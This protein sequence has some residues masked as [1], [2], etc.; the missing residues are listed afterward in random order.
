VGLDASEPEITEVPTP[1]YRLA[2]YTGALCPEGSIET[3]PLD[4]FVVNFP[5]L[6]EPGTQECVLHFVLT[7]PAGYR[8]RR[9]VFR[10]TGSAFRYD[11]DVS[12]TPVTVSYAMLDTRL[13]SQHVVRSYPL[14]NIQSTSYWLYDTPKLIAPDCSDPTQ[15]TELDLEVGIKTAVPEG[16]VT[17]IDW[18]EG[19]LEYGVE[20]TTCERGFPDRSKN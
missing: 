20:W 3:G 16:A 4:P 6:E 8:F 14:S 7:I 10:T 13:S 17:T 2:S 19:N 15:P 5:A 11:D 9:P 18:I 1:S 12:L